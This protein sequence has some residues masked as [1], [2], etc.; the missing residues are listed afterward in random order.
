MLFKLNNEEKSVLKALPGTTFE[1]INWTEK[2]LENLVANNI[3][4]LLPE[5][6]LMVFFQER[7]LREEADIYAL[8]KQGDLYIFEL[9]RWKSNQENLLQVM[10]YG[11]I[12]GQYEYEQLETM[13]RKYRKMADLDLC[14]VHKDYF[15]EQIDEPLNRH[16]FNGDQHFVVITNG[17]DRETLK[18][19]QY[20]QKKGIKIDSIIYRLYRLG[21]DNLIFEFNPYN[22]EKEIIIEEDEGF[23]IVNTNLTWSDLNYKEMLEEGKA[24]AYYDRKYGIMN[25][26]KDDTVF[27]YHTGVG[28]IAYG[29]AINNYKS[30]DINGDKEAEY[31]IKIKFDWKIDPDTQKEM[32][33]QSWEINAALQSGYR[34]RQTVFSIDKKMAEEIIKLAKSKKQVNG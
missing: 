14:K 3:A 2:D 7:K 31:Y 21:E 30:K 27:L 13:L 29:K 11:Q 22:P 5:N 6:Q 16:E 12:F 33:V 32:A 4:K 18:A 17:I 26:K 20:W 19:I 10:R 15:I 23:F 25:I 24:A 34:F 1:R 9:K 8:D 28:I